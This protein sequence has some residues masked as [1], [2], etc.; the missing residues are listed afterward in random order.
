G[1]VADV[2]RGGV[3]R[4]AGLRADH[5]AAIRG[6]GMNATSPRVLV[7]VPTYNERDNIATLV[8]QLLACGPSYGVLVVDDQSPDGTG[9]V[10]DAL[11]ARYPGRVEAMHRTGKRGLGRS[12]VDALSVAITRDVDV[13]CQMDAD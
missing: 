8:E 12:Y 4:R 3:S 2:C 13:I 1:A 10:V 9:E 6:T 7:V 11:A 5:H